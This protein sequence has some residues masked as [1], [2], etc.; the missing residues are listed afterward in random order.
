MLPIS[1]MAEIIPN[2]EIL[3][4][5]IPLNNITS[6][7]DVDIEIPVCKY[8]KDFALTF[9]GDDA[10]MGIY[11][12]AFNY[13]HANYIDNTD[14]FHDYGKP[15]TTGFTPK[16]KLVTTDGCGND[17][18]FRLCVNWFSCEPGKTMHTNGNIYTP[19]MWW[20]E[21]EKFTDFHNG[22]LN[23]G[24][25][26]EKEDPKKSIDFNFDEIKENLGINAFILGV[27]G[28][29][30]GFPDEA[31]INT[32]VYFMEAANFASGASNNTV[33]LSKL[34][35]DNILKTRSPRI[36]VD[37]KDHTFINEIID[38]KSVKD[39]W[40]NLFC[41][42][43]KNSEAKVN[44]Q[45]NADTCYN[46]LDYIYDNYGKGGKDNVWFASSSE[47]LEYQYSRLNSEIIKEV[48]D[49]KLKITIKA[50]ILSGFYF[51]ELSLNMS[52]IKDCSDIYFS[53]NI[54]GYSL[55]CE[56][57]KAIVN[58]NYSER[59]IKL[60][61]KYIEKVK[62]DNNEKS[63]SEAMYFISNLRPELKEE[64]LKK[65]NQIT[66]LS[67]LND[68]NDSYFVF[69]GKKI[70]V[71]A[72]L[73]SSFTIYNIDG[74]VFKTIDAINSDQYIELPK[75]LYLLRQKKLMVY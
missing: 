67:S 27:P 73:K 70:I 72:Q 46:M 62:S 22:I 15:V 60:T 19:Q 38:S 52:G 61:E 40:I 21:G 54:F 10:L 53:D 11:Q 51:N 13:V 45:I 66:S 35:K 71:S 55:A 65:L 47:I 75:G 56:A 29:S 14:I 68:D 28:G 48:V 31:E 50:A 44:G 17:K 23:H 12:R 1:L 59:D 32:N 30:T 39:G 5:E 34:S 3:T 6:L 58:L 8:N 4:I 69:D 36:C 9:T 49:N 20:S 18:P 25:A 16:R 37:T 42:N 2:Y 63:I 24:G 41:H 64:Y 74:S 33:N 43:I 26:Y 57:N 7:E